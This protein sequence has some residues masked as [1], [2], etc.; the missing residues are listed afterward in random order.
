MR[1]SSSGLD[2]A[3]TQAD[4]RGIEQPIER[5]ATAHEA[6]AFAWRIG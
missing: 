6:H 4:L 1:G 5:D 3:G 2:K